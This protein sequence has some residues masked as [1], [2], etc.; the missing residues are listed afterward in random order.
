[1]NFLADECSKLAAGIAEKVDPI[2]LFSAVW[3]V[4]VA[5]ATGSAKRFSTAVE[6]V[7]RLGGV[8][9]MSL[10]RPNGLQDLESLAS[11]SHE[12]V[13]EFS[14]IDAFREDVCQ[15]ADLGVPTFDAVELALR[16]LTSDDTPT[17]WGGCMVKILAARQGFAADE[18]LPTSPVGPH[19]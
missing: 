14:T 13:Y 4:H 2:A 10:L 15:A 7:E 8:S 19:S 5:A 16:A 12:R 1:L 6:L 18:Y 9:E 17:W 11:R 3:N